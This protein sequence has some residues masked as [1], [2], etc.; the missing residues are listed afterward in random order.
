MLLFFND[1]LGTFYS[2]DPDDQLF[3]VA[4]IDENFAYFDTLAHSAL[5]QTDSFDETI[6]GMGQRLRHIACAKADQRPT[7]VQR[8]DHYLAGFARRKGCAGVRVADL[9][10]PVRLDRVAQLS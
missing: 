1:D 10:E 7:A 6:R 3:H 2:R 4:W 9:D 8:G 5:Q